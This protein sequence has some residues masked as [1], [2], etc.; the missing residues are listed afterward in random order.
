MLRDAREWFDGAAD[1][2]IRALEEVPGIDPERLRE[3]WCAEP[4]LMLRLDRLHTAAQRA[5]ERRTRAAV[6]EDLLR[7]LRAVAQGADVARLETAVALAGTRL[8]ADTAT[9]GARG[10][11]TGLTCGIVVSP[12]IL[13][14]VFALGAWVPR[15]FGVELGCQPR[16]ALAGA[17]VCFAGGAMGAVF[18]VIVRLRDPRQLIRDSVVVRDG[19]GG[20]GPD[21]DPVQLCRSLR[22]EGWY[23][24]VVGWFLATA[25][26]LLVAGGILTVLTPPATPAE[27]C[28]P[29]P[30]SAEAH[31][32]LVK[33]WFFWGAIGFLAGLN[34]RW[35][36]GLLRHPSAP[37][38]EAAGPGEGTRRP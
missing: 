23:R 33:T 8:E 1:G 34:E 30:L 37:V 10:L 22:Q 20:A 21:A 28:G 7:A 5:F 13:V 19:T 14:V 32:A 12:V 9:A 18:S 31:G 27:L 17:L 36:R 6:T 3:L 15:I 25:L 29:G 35:A 11:N 2:E 16:L 4:E 38:G 24:V 26:Y